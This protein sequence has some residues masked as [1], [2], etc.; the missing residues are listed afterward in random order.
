MAVTP[1]S[2]VSADRDS[3]ATS[4]ELGNGIGDPSSSQFSWGCDRESKAN[5]RCRTEN[6]EPGL[7]RRP[8]KPHADTI[9]KSQ[10]EPEAIAYSFLVLIF[11]TRSSKMM[12]PEAHSFQDVANSSSESLRPMR[13]SN[14][15]RN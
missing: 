3:F 11:L 1:Q 7:L 6:Q 8:A 2:Q 12:W 15:R 5:R 13:L 14:Q 10:K 9:A 4:G